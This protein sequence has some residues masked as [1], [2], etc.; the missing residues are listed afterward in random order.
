MPRSARL[1]SGG[2]Q[3]C[4]GRGEWRTADLQTA[5]AA[6]D[7]HATGTADFKPPACA[8]RRD[9]RRDVRAKRGLREPSNRDA[10]ALLTQE[11]IF[12]GAAQRLAHQLRGPAPPAVRPAAAKLRRQTA[13]RHDW[14][15][16]GPRQLHALVR[17]RAYRPF[18]RQRTL[19]PRLGGSR[20]HECAVSS[21][22]LA[23]TP[24][25]RS[26][27]GRHAHKADFTLSQWYTVSLKN[28][29]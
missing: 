18:V 10:T 1:E 24:A 3:P 9:P 5:P 4:E 25:C 12:S 17:R 6:C 7:A 21:G 28:S 22:R 16:A 13:G 15:D 11:Q 23:H 20:P 8:M 26:D 2:N 19:T 27:S 29:R 14:S